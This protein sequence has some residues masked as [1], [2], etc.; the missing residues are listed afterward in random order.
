M[1]TIRSEKEVNLRER[2]H[3]VFSVSQWETARHD[4]K[5]FRMLCL[6]I[7]N[8]VYGFFHGRFDECAGVDDNIPRGQRIVRVR[9]SA[10]EE[11]RENT[12]RIHSVLRTPETYDVNCLTVSHD[13][14]KNLVQEGVA[15]AARSI[16]QSGSPEENQEK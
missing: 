12:F 5:C 11:G 15:A 6:D 2:I 4:D 7:E 14:Q 1:D 10:V 16:F 8:C 13:Y 3:E 9:I